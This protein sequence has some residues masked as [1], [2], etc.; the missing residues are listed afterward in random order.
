MSIHGKLYFVLV[1]FVG[2]NLSIAA[3]TSDLKLTCDCGQLKGSRIYNALNGYEDHPCP[4]VCKYE[5]ST[6]LVKHA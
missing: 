2:I 6:G 4:L 1:I 5:S 3:I